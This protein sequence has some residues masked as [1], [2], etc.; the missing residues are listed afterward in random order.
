LR[1]SF[2]SDQQTIEAPGTVVWG[3][4][5]AAERAASLRYGLKWTHRSVEER[6]RLRRLIA[7]TR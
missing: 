3:D 1:L 4:L 7:T 2:S 5:H 6:D